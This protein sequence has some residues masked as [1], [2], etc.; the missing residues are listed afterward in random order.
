[1]QF[2]IP[3]TDS[4]F[5]AL[6]RHFVQFQR[7]K[8]YQ[9]PIGII[10]HQ[11]M[12][13]STRLFFHFDKHSNWGFN[14]NLISFQQIFCLGYWKT[15]LYKKSYIYTETKDVLNHENNVDLLDISLYL[16]LRIYFSQKMIKFLMCCISVGIYKSYTATV[17]SHYLFISNYCHRT[18]EGSTYL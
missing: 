10:F 13:V 1:M 2:I 16:R 5:L 7:K 3:D 6:Y 15:R 9:L 8:L 4:K 18:S 11:Q 12:S 17:E 14:F